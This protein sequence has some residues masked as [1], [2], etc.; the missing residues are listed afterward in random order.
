MICYA[1]TSS[2]RAVRY[3]T[4]AR[5]KLCN[6]CN[7]MKFLGAKRDFHALE[8]VRWTTAH[9]ARTVGVLTQANRKKKDRQKKIIDYCKVKKIECKEFEKWD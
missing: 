1:H 9:L 4:Q 2:L 3:F 6:I 5:T 8:K 7:T